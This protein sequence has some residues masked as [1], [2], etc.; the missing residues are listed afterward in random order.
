[1]KHKYFIVILLLTTTSLFSQNR[2]KQFALYSTVGAKG[3]VGASF[4]KNANMSADNNLDYKS[5]LFY[6]YG[7]KTSLSYL[8]KAPR[9]ALLGFYF[10]Y[11]WGAYPIKF[12]KIITDN[13]SY[14]KTVDLKTNDMVLTFRYTNVPKKWMLEAGSQFTKYRS[15]NHS[16]SVTDSNFDYLVDDY[17][18]EDNYQDYTSLVLG[19]G[20]FFKGAVVSLR[21][22]TSLSSITKP[23]ANPIKDGY[24]NSELVNTNYSQQYNSTVDTKHNTILLTIEYYIPFIKLKRSSCGGSAFYFFKNIDTT[25]YWGR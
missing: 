16:N 6:S 5:G 1:M 23:D 3:T 2:G 8:G 15:I 11:L 9:N 20:V 22:T 24:Y 10:D 25:Y 7:L 17:K 13:G 12:T 4:I 19:A 21:Y 14:N 18:Y